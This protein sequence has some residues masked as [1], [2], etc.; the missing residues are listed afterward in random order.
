VHGVTA[1]VDAKVEEQPIS[2][3]VGRAKLRCETFEQRI[4]GEAP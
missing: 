1:V 2:G 3:L 4:V